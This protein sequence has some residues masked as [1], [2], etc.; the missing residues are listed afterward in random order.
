MVVES[1]GGKDEQAGRGG[2]WGAETTPGGSSVVE[3][4]TCFSKSVEWTLMQTMGFGDLDVLMGVHH[5]E[6]MCHFVGEQ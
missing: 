2:S 1:G 3:C 5:T 4:V 6:Q